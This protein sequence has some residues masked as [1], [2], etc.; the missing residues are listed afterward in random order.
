MIAKS[1]DVGNIDFGKS[2][3]GFKWVLQERDTR[4]IRTLSQKLD[5][6]EVLASLI[7][8][9]GVKTA[10]EGI[11]FL[12]PKLKHLLADPYH[13]KDMDK[14]VVRTVKAIS[15]HQ[16]IAVFGDYDVDGAT[17][18]ALL[19]RVFRALGMSVI[20]YIPSRL[21]EGYGLSNAALENL[22]KQGAELVIT[23][24]CGM[25]SFKPVSHGNN[26]GLDIIII[27]H[28]MGLESVPEAIAVIN[29]NRVDDTSEFKSMAAVGV[30]FMFTIALRAKLREMGWFTEHCITEPNLLSFL[31]LVALGTVC[32]VMPL[33]GIN[34][35][36]VYQGLK[37]IGQRRNP[38]IRAIADIAKVDDTPQ[39]YHLGYVIGPRINAGG[40]IGEGILGSDVLATDSYEEAHA[41]AL[42]LE[43][44]NDERRA[45]EAIALEDAIEQVESKKLYENTVIFVQ[46]PDW[47]AG[48][49][50]ILASK[51]KEKYL[52]PVAALLITE[53]VA[54]G[55]ARSIV[56]LDISK[57]VSQAKAI[58]LLLDGGGHAMAAGLTLLPERLEEF[59]AYI[60]EQLSHSRDAA[61]LR[62]MELPIDYVFTA[63]ALNTELMALIGQAGPFGQGN[64][65][66]KFALCDVILAHSSIVGGK[67]VLN[68]VHE[69][70]DTGRKSIKCMLFNGAQT[71][72]GSILLKSIGKKISLAGTVQYNTFDH[73][74]VD[75]IIEDAAFK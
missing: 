75:F 25:L 31:D 63:S 7:Y 49:L 48:I 57:V 73:S 38:G 71:P 37:I 44:L 14:A 22:Q 68:V 52:R 26:I 9:R 18:T 61:L 53:E 32:D 42:K 56:G 21:K 50:G 27:D 66:P 2:V 16:K 74:K 3:R 54:K 10:D 67:H 1:S 46:S 40:R 55:S 47:H 72:L 60:N 58:G 11:R 64:P 59:Y 39:A 51:L 43:T 13:L 23:V 12:E 70:Q 15:E 65:M 30:A 4:T 6:P 29:P 20:T 62:A 19:R 45:V 36:F 69:H 8:N 24:D 34:R 35:A 33:Q 5:I 17:S 41:I 28:H